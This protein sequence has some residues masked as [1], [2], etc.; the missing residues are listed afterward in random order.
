M[1]HTL[2]YISACVCML[3]TALTV[4]A[5]Q[6]E[7]NSLTPYWEY[8]VG[9]YG[10]FNL[11]QHSAGMQGLPTIPSCCP[12]YSDGTGTGMMIGGLV[13]FFLAEKF[14]LQGRVSLHSGG[15]LLEAR[16]T[17]TVNTDGTAQTG[18]FE[19]TIKSKHMWLNIEPLITFSPADKFKILLGPTVGLLMSASFSQKEEILEPS[20]ATFEN[21]STTRAI[22]SGDIPQTN[23]LFVGITGGLRYEIPISGNMW[24]IAPE[25]FYTFGLTNLQQNEAW[26]MNALRFGLAVQYN[27]WV[28]PKP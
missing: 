5:Q 28:T 4:S 3:V 27:S 18:V 7:D 9:L 10:S 6:T 14:S 20:D 24:S 8:S 2:C 21:D 16:E 23:T 22:Y 1:K 26:K 11:D 17:E 19:H 25:V 13:D 12:E 15:G